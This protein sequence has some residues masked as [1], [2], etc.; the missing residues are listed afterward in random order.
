MEKKEITFSMLDQRILHLSNKEEPFK[1]LFSLVGERSF[2]LQSNF[3]EALVMSIIG[4]QL[5]A[6]AANTIR[7]RFKSLYDECSVN[8]V[9]S[10]STSELQSVGISRAKVSYISDLCERITN[11]EI[12]F[13]GMS[14]MSNDEVIKILT[15]VKGIGRWTAEM[16]LI[17]SLGRMNISSFFDAG[18]QRASKWLYQMEN[19]PDGKYLEQHCRV[20]G[21]VFQP[22][23][24]KPYVR[25]SRIRLSDVLHLGHYSYLHM[26]LLVS[27]L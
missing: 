5:S 6:K 25:F 15:S 18:L 21:W 10:L 4:Q 16:F 3:F 14:C 24:I 1:K 9:K 7:N 2:T 13:T 11:G 17:F 12:D 22:L 19:R 26:R 23:L 8:Q 27:T 20:K